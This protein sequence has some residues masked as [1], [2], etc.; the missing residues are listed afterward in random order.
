VP[1]LPP[2][3][4]LEHLRKQAK[5]RRRERG[6]GLSRAQYEIARD[7]GFSSW[8]RLVHHVQTSTLDGI[9]RAL[10]LA[11][12]STLARLLHADQTAATTTVDGLEPLLVLLRRAT[13]APADVRSCARM[14]LDAGADP[15]SHTIEWGGEG[16]MSALFD[17]VERGA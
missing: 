16:G 14:L 11:D 7:Y 12:T 9:E 13:D 8:P 17:A 5:T 10:V 4:S 1:D 3:P 15:D 6:I 2:H